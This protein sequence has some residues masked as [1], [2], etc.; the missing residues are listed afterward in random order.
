MSTPNDECKRNT[1]AL[2]DLLSAFT[3]APLP[4]EALLGTALVHSS[5]VQEGRM[6][7]L[8]DNERLEFLGDAV[9]ELAV[10]RWLFERFPDFAEGALT[11]TRAMLVRTHTLA[12]AAKRWGLD[13][14]VICGN[15]GLR[16]GTPLPKVLAGCVEAVL[17]AVSLQVD[18]ARMQQLIEALFAEEL[19]KAGTNQ[20]FY[21]Y[22]SKLQQETHALYGC[23]P[24]YV[25]LDQSGPPHNRRFVVEVRLGGKPRGRGQ[26]RSKKQA[27]QAAAKAALGREGPT[28]VGAGD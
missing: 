28:D 9:L 16:E 21:D 6:P 2:K 10:T 8:E 4:D 5:A 13:K 11:K 1:K 3:N 20:L 24:E 7:E 23:P 18:F 27:E 25:V 14:L 12:A 17:G 22:K 15:S 26:G 19:A